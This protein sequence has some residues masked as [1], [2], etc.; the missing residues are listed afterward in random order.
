MMYIILWLNQTVYLKCLD[1]H[2]CIQQLVNSTIRINKVMLTGNTGIIEHFVRNA[3]S[4][5]VWRLDEISTFHIIWQLEV[6]DSW[7]YST[8][9]IKLG[10]NKRLC[11]C[12]LIFRHFHV[13]KC[14]IRYKFGV[15]F[16]KMTRFDLKSIYKAETGSFE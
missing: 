8:L 9:F 11:W 10:L 3:L 5:S 13:V 2:L 1:V 14:Q 16:V 12:C 15:H 6:L 7:Q 4:L